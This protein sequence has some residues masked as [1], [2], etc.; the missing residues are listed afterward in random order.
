MVE[1]VAF[2]ALASCTLAM[3]AMAGW[4]GLQLWNEI[5]VQRMNSAVVAALSEGTYRNSYRYRPRG[6]KK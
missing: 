4:L 1:F 5:K 2:T 6:A 3:L